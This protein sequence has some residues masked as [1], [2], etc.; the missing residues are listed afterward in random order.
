MLRSKR[1][2]N[3][4]L[5]T[6]VAL[7]LLLSFYSAAQA[8]EPVTIKAI[9]MQGGGWVGVTRELIPQFT[10]MTGIEVEIE[11][12]PY[13]N[14]KDKAILEMDGKTGA[15]DIVV[16]DTAWL[17]EFADAGYVAALD[18]Y[19]EKYEV[20][21]DGYLPP[22]LAACHYRD[23]Y[24]A[25]PFEIDTRVL[26][27]NTRMLKEAGIVDEEGNP[28]IPKT[29]DEFVEAAIAMTLD[30]NGNNPNDADFDADNIVQYGFC[31]TGQA[32]P[33][34][35]LDYAPFMWGMG[36]DILQY[37]DVRDYTV[38]LD[39][40][41]TLESLTIYVDIMRKWH[42]SPEASATYEENQQDDFIRLGKAAMGILP[43][44]SHAGHM[45]GS[46]GFEDTKIKGEMA[47]VPTPA[48]PPN[49]PTTRT[50]IWAI[51]IPADS[52]YIDEAFQFAAW[53]TSDPEAAKQYALLGGAT[54]WDA[55]WE[56]PEVVDKWPFYP[57]VKEVMLVSI[58]EPP[59]PEWG[60]IRQ[61]FGVMA[62]EALTG[63]KTPEEAIKDATAKMK[64]LLEDA[65]YPNP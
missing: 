45:E 1:T 7:C 5:T 41:E 46:L 44:P 43:S 61:I 20:N 60:E 42:A 55:A 12:Q 54:P 22:Q 29:V 28:K 6:V 14:L 11:E 65:G 16:L 23:N 59:I 52:K 8:E 30:E 10:G 36:G 53:I 49:K 9:M 63:V 34:I 38:V 2:F 56:D 32:G 62:S 4:A 3:L 35:A 21:L 33:Y 47:F 50:G 15:Y 48:N 27:V 58:A 57:A 39:S 64:Q 18:E 13:T 37:N 51:F 40:P 17:A 26:G 24:F 25:V 31:H 19:F